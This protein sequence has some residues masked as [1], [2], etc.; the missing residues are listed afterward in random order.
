M[1]LLTKISLG[2]MTGVGIIG[3]SVGASYF[4][5]GPNNVKEALISANLT[6]L[7]KDDTNHTEDW[8]KLAKKYA[9]G[10]AIPK[11]GEF[12]IVLEGSEVKEGELQKFQAECEKLFNKKPKDSDYQKSLDLAKSWCVKEEAK[13]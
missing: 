2:A 1:T 6:P 3:G 9:G 8:K 4:L 13:E 12:M 7:S 10:D 5:S 11:I